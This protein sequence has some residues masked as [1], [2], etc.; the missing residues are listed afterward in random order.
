M[1]H[2]S[3]SIIT[4]RYFFPSLSC[5]TV[6]LLPSIFNSSIDW[7]KSKAAF[8][9]ID[10]CTLR[11]CRWRFTPLYHVTFW[12]LRHKTAL[13]L[14]MERVSQSVGSNQVT[15]TCRTQGKVIVGQEIRFVAFQLPLR[16]QRTEA[17][18]VSLS[19]DFSRTKVLFS[20]RGQSWTAGGVQLDH[21]P[22]KAKGTYRDHA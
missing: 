4:Q 21:R 10:F 17:N 14:P 7:N 8:S 13:V 11:N 5:P 20:Q 12:T 3:E 22:T 19:S 18:F 9:N 6:K 2:L 16:W 1:R 15:A